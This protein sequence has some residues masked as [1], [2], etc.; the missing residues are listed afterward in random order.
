MRLKDALRTVLDLA[1]Q[2]A[3][4]PDEQEEGSRLQEEALRQEE[5]L[6]DVEKLWVDTPSNMT[7]RL[8]LVEQPPGWCDDT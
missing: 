6:A 1:Q 4:E 5:A 7:P 3:L 2:N 8:G